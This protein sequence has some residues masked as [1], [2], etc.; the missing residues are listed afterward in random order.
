MNKKYRLVKETDNICLEKYVIYKIEKRIRFLFW[1][2]WVVR[3]REVKR[4]E[5]ENMYEILTGKKKM[6]E[7]E[8][9]S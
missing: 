7:R 6:I 5:A 2:W 9:I 3:C 8:I 1:S 4:E